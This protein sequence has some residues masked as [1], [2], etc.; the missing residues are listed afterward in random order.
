MSA[1]INGTPKPE[2]AEVKQVKLLPP[3]EPP[4]IGDIWERRGSWLVRLVE[5]LAHFPREKYLVLMVLMALVAV[6]AS[7]L[8][9]SHDVTPARIVGAV[10]VSVLITGFGVMVFFS[11]KPNGKA[12]QETRGEPP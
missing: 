10:V 5:S 2:I 11:S 1:D 6:A 4:S 9:P 7:I 8:W 12:N 3:S